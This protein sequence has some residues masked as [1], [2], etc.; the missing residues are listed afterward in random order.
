MNSTIQQVQPFGWVDD[1]LH[2]KLYNGPIYYFLS[3][4][5]SLSCL[6]RGTERGWQLHLAW[7]IIIGKK[8][9][10]LSKI[11]VKYDHKIATYC[12][13]TDIESNSKYEALGQERFLA[14]F[15]M[16]LV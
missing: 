11:H 13:L 12:L 7:L 15:I 4:A 2:A 16:T 6:K 9:S 3:K 1:T 8:V 5:S 10:I 14:M